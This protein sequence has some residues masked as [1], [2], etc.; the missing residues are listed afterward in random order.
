MAGSMVSSIMAKVKMRSN[1]QIEESYKNLDLSDVLNGSALKD[2]FSTTA[3]RTIKNRKH[4]KQMSQQI[5][6]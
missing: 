2:P 4:L 3:R 6:A 5:S 1:S